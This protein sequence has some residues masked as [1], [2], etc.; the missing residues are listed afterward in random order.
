M[1]KSP[2]HRFS[3]NKKSPSKSPRSKD[4]SLTRGQSGKHHVLVV[5]AAVATVH[6]VHVPVLAVVVHHQKRRLFL[7]KSKNPMIR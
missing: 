7:Q 4:S 2:K 3:S 5:V 1:V 6:R